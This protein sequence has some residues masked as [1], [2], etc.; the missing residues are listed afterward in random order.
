MG[1]GEEELSASQP[2]GLER[3]TRR[4][5]GALL[6][7]RQRAS[8]LRRRSEKVKSQIA[9]L[10]RICRGGQSHRD[11]GQAVLSQS[12]LGRFESH[13]HACINGWLP[14]QDIPSH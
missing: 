6:R 7:L 11:V 3:E 14:G 13:A 9:P 8:K 1:R 5:Q 10:R 12:R 2:S 4:R